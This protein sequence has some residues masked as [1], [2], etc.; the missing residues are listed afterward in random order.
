MPSAPDTLPISFK[1][2]EQFGESE[3][4]SHSVPGSCHPLGQKGH[5]GRR[6]AR[7]PWVR[8]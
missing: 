4:R 3:A 1:N 5:R 7:V 6:K 2:H 8:G